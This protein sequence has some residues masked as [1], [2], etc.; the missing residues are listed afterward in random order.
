M[1]K[2]T[3]ATKARRKANPSMS[4]IQ[5]SG[6]VGLELARRH[7]LSQRL[8]HGPTVSAGTRSCGAR[9]DGQQPSGRMRMARCA[10]SFADFE[11]QQFPG[12]PAPP[13]ATTRYCVPQHVGHRAAALGGRHVDCADFGSVA[14]SKARNMAPRCPFGVGPKLL[15]PA[16]SSVLVTSVP[17]LLPDDRAAEGSV[18]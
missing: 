7:R 13:I 4:V 6:P 1:R 8:T 11:H 16:T 17:P 15:S 12:C 2:T 10:A 3:R 18:P 14:L 9:N 5:E